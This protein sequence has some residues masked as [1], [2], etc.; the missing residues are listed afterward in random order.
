MRIVEH[1]EETVGMLRERIEYLEIQ[2]ESSCDERSFHQSLDPLPTPPAT[3]IL[4][5][6]D[7]T[8]IGTKSSF[9]L[10]SNQTNL[11]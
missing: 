4:D 11:H 6:L 7:T 10:L 2:L 3:P 8:L 5:T 1:S 9:I